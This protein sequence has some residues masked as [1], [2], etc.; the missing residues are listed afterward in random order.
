L[1]SP[2]THSTPSSAADERRTAVFDQAGVSL[3]LDG[4]S[5]SK[6]V[7]DAPAKTAAPLHS[8]NTHLCGAAGG[9]AGQPVHATPG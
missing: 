4:G 6:R 8:V 1:A 9:A 2:I 7:T 5:V 3:L